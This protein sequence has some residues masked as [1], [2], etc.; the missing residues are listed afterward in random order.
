MLLIGLGHRE[1]Q[2]MGAGVLHISTQLCKY[3]RKQSEK[4]TQSIGTMTSSRHF[5]RY[6]KGKA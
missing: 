6:N 3:S 1:G 2:K 4:K 5:F